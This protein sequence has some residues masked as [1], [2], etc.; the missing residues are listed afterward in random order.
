MKTPHSISSWVPLYI[1]IG[2]CITGLFWEEKLKINSSDH[3][4]MAVGIL[5]FSYLWINRWITHN[6]RNFLDVE[7]SE[8]PEGR[9][10]MN[11]FLAGEELSEVNKQ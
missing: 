1:L 7:D 3:I 10:A 8:M 11:I 5:L 9:P 4:L 6:M 2:V